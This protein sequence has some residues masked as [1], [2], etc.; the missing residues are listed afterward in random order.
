MFL[1]RASSY[2]GFFLAIHNHGLA[3][4][5]FHLGN[6][7]Y[8]RTLIFLLSVVE[9]CLVCMTTEDQVADVFVGSST[10]FSSK[11]F[12]WRKCSN[13]EVRAIRRMTSRSCSQ[14]MIFQHLDR[15]ITHCWQS[16]RL[17]NYSRTLPI[18]IVVLSSLGTR[19][20]RYCCLCAKDSSMKM[21][22]CAT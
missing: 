4:M 15:H 2:I 7:S 22:S 6:E 10:N 8:S 21:P 5:R 12:W 14:M 16:R 3:M 1:E 19:G 13:L 11:S 17:S 9:Q 18:K 20:Q